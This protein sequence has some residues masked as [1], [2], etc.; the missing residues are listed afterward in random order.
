MKI[1]VNLIPINLVTKW[2]LYLFCS[3][4]EPKIKIKVLGNYGGLVT[5]KFGFLL[6]VH[7]QFHARTEYPN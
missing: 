1:T 6:T 7:L 5:K 2:L 3:F 4:V